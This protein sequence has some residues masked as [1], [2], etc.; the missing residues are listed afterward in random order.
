MRDNFCVLP[1]TTGPSQPP[2]ALP[3]H[4][5]EQVTPQDCAKAVEG[6]G[7]ARA[8]SE[9]ALRRLRWAG[10]VLLYHRLRF[11]PA[12][13]GTPGWAMGLLAGSVAAI[14]A[15]SLMILAGAGL[16]ATFL[17]ILILYPTC[18]GAVMWF[19]RDRDGEHE[20]N[21]LELRTERLKTAT[22]TLDHA[23]EFLGAKKA[24]QDDAQ[25]RWQ[26]VQEAFESQANQR[27]IETER[28][29][30]IDPGRLHPDEFERHVGAIFRHLGFSVQGVGNI[31][32]D[33][34]V[35]LIATRDSLRVAVQA[36]RYIGS[37]GNQAV[38]QVYAGMAHYKC[39]R[40]VVV[41]TGEFT[42]AA[43]AL[44]KST[45]CLLIGAERIASLIRG[46]M[47]F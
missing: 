4:P 6:F 19:L 16:V 9:D 15:G 8:A 21:R 29:L 32:G 42:A 24:A 39:H 46:E 34:G 38:Q 33:Q 7:I 25:R 13:F 14:W 45:G 37:V 40:C 22:D 17:T 35:D 12:R 23:R 28:L 2:A 18:G 43:R 20:A 1:D 10:R 31:A 36:K 5:V 27:K 41:T 44:A 11:W 30:Q 47:E 26:A 3:A